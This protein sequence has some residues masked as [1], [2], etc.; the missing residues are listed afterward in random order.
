VVS[1]SSP[2]G[3]LLRLASVCAILANGQTGRN[4]V[5]IAVGIKLQQTGY[6]NTSHQ[7]KDD[8]DKVIAHLSVHMQIYKH[9][10]PQ[11]LCP[12]SPDQDTWTP[13]PGLHT[14]TYTIC[15][16]TKQCAQWLQN[17]VIRLRSGQ[18]QTL[19]TV[20]NI[21]TTTKWQTSFKTFESAIKC[22]FA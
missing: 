9:C 10:S 21:A 1:S 11:T 3:K 2:R 19:Q 22:L 7:T 16:K 4:A 20:S 5:L 13:S 17:I 18:M 15:N 8:G 14:H 6:S 12:K